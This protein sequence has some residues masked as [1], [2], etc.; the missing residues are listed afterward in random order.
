MSTFRAPDDMQPQPAPVTARLAQGAIE[1][2]N[3]RAVVE[4]SRMIELTRT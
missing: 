2:S 4:M 3:V 1:K